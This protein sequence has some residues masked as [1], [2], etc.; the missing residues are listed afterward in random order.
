M[1]RRPRPCEYHAR[2]SYEP[3][4]FCEPREPNEYCDLDDSYG[5]DDSY[6]PDDS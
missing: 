4:K 3:D 5:C 6:N 1:W 2:E